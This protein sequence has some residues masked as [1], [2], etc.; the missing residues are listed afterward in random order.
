[1]DYKI[2]YLKY[3]SKYLEL[4]NQQIGGNISDT[5]N[6]KSLFSG[7]LN[8]FTNDK[9][10]KEE[11]IEKRKEEMIKRGEE[12][13]NRLAKLE[14]SKPVNG[15]LEYNGHQYNDY[16]L[17]NVTIPPSITYIENMAFHNNKLTSI[18]IPN[19]VKWI[20]VLA[21]YKNQ[22]KS[23][24]IPNSV[25]YIGEGAFAENQLTSIT[26]PRS[27]TYIGKGAFAINRQLKS[28]DIY[29]QLGGLD[30][31]KVIEAFDEGV[32]INY[33]YT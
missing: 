15:Y 20:G 9:K 12:T 6:E 4:K 8:F 7:F 17:T 3:K 21:F 16:G 11:E 27:V 14:R 31:D 1:M 22:L 10:T 2:K 25:T 29:W 18:I 26:I 24:I 28:V 30:K 23:V 13:K 32:T 19:S 5:K 33:I